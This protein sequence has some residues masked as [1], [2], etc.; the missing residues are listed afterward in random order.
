MKK[1]ENIQIHEAI[2]FTYACHSKS[3]S[4]HSF[5]EQNK[6]KKSNNQA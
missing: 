4:F 1:E 2:Q 3:V 6:K 5:E